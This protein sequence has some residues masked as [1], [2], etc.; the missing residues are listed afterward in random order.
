MMTPPIRF[1]ARILLIFIILLPLV[2]HALAAGADRS[3]GSNE[4][5]VEGS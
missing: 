1:V 5:H 3:S 2:R 4:G